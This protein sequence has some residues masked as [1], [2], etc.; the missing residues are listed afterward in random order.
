M[1]LLLPVVAALCVLAAALLLRPLWWPSRPTRSRELVAI[2]EGLRV[3][4]AQLKELH[5]AGTLTD[6]QFDAGRQLV[7]KKL[8]DVLAEAPAS[9]AAAPAAQA[10]SARMAA[11]MVAFVVVFASAGYV[12]LGSPGHAAGGREA[13]APM[14]AGDDAG[15]AAPH[16]L[17]AE[18]VAR[19]IEQLAQ[20]LKTKPDDADGWQMLARSY[21][22]IG[23]HAEA[24]EAF[25][26][27]ARLAPKDAGLLAD[28][29]DALAM[30]NGRSLAGEPAT[31]VERALQ[32]DPANPKALALAGTIAFDRK[33]Y[34]EAVKRWEQ[35]VAAEPADSPLAQQARGGIAEARELAGMPP[36]AP[37]TVLAGAA[38][39]AGPGGATAAPA[40]ARVSGTIT[41]ADSLKGRVAPDDTLFVFARASGSQRMPVAILRKR[42]GDLPL[43]FTLDDS[44]AMS[45]EVRLSKVAKV[46][47]GA[48][49]S[50][51]GNALPQDGDLQGLGSEVAVGANGVKI[52]I[53]Q[54]VTR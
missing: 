34:R 19:M 26:A 50:K 24:V 43:Q 4:L 3:Q 11:A 22:A 16:P 38:A 10:P 21:V 12:W 53:N 18:Q 39:A 45:D 36:A 40:G 1:T 14:A 7:E 29:A 31:L 13:A 23:K 41:L 35:L 42:A 37:P 44:M 8:L 48:R 52:E 54:T 46:V 5:A 47:V 25:K 30:A 9:A 49:I 20:R 33:D 15:A 6:E 17:T 32:I 28:Y 2:V 27:A 51:S